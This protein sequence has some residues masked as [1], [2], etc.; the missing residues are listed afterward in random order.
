MGHRISLKLIFL[1]KYIYLP[2]FEPGF[3]DFLIRF[4]LVLRLL[5]VPQVGRFVILIS[6]RTSGWSHD[7]LMFVGSSLMRSTAGNASSAST[8]RVPSNSI[9]KVLLSVTNRIRLRNTLI[10]IIPNEI[11]FIS[12]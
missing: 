2:F 9:N 1:T 8:E 4:R 6:R 10:T 3:A 12:C 11:I 5:L 7:T